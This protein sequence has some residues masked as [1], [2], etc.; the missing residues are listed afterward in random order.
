MSDK[1]RKRLYIAIILV[2]IGMMIAGTLYLVH[3]Y[4]INKTLEEI[5]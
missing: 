5:H 3:K 1:I 4:S 2:L